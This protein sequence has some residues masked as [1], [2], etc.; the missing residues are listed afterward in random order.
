MFSS[1]VVPCMVHYNCRPISGGADIIL[2]IGDLHFP[3]V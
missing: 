3:M 1:Y 2:A